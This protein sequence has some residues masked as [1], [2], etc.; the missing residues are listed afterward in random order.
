MRL[1]YISLILAI[2][3]PSPSRGQQTANKI[4]AKYAEVTGG[5]KN[6]KKIRN[7]KDSSVSCSAREIYHDKE[8]DTT[9]VHYLVFYTESSG[10]Y[11]DLAYNSDGSVVSITT[12]DNINRYIYDFYNGI[13]LPLR[14][15]KTTDEFKD[16]YISELFR[17]LDAKKIEYI[18]KEAQNEKIHEKLRVYEKS[19]RFVTIWYFDQESGLLEKINVGEEIVKFSTYYKNYQNI[20][21]FLIPMRTETQN[22]AGNTVIIR[23]KISI[24]FNVEVP[25]NFYQLE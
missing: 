5:L 10:K 3:F 13:R 19:N 17:L 6:W 9:N 11:R 15:R 12:Q 14:I 4:V 7:V 16:A 1:V 25:K 18:G 20:E 21:G 24:E 23:D 2:H 8:V 22:E